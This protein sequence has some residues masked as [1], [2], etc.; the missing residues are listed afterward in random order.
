LRWKP[1]AIESTCQ[2]DHLV[3]DLQLLRAR[4]AK[5]A[6]V[7]R[8]REREDHRRVLTHDGGQVEKHFRVVGEVIGQTGISQQPVALGI[9]A[10]V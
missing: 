2:L 5:M 10:S 8:T 6:L 9:A 1:V 7:V 4:L 3:D